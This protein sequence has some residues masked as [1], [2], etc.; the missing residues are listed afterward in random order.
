VKL[1]TKIVLVVIGLSLLVNMVSLILFMSDK[2][3]NALSQL[4]HK[5]ENIS[6]LLNQVNSGPLYDADVLVL[7]TNLKSFLNDAEI[8]SI[9]LKE[10]NGSINVHFDKPELV[11]ESIIKDETIITYNH[12]KI[13]VVTTFYSTEYIDSQ[14]YK[15]ISQL[16]ISF[17]F[18]TFIIS[19][20]LYLL[21]KK[22]T[23]PIS[24]LTVLSTEIANGN[25]EKEIDIVRYDEIGILS[26]SFMTMRDSIKSKIYSL[27]LENEE[28][29]LTEIELVKAK[30][31]IGNIINSMPSILIGV[32]AKGKVTQ[33]NRAAEQFTGL[34]ADSTLGKMLSDVYPNLESEI[35][36]ISESI[37]TQTIKQEQ[38]RK[39]LT[40]NGFCYEDVTIFPLIDS[41][42]EGVVIRID[43]VTKR[44]QLEE[45]M[46]QSERMLSIGGL[47]AGMAHEINNPL[48][49]MMQTANVMENRLV[50]KGLSA[51]LKAASEAGTSMDAIFSFMEARGILRMVT[52][53]NE[54]GR[55]IAEIVDNMLSF[56]RK[57]DVIS[58]SQNITELLDKTLELAATDYDLKKQYDFKMIRII[59]EYAEELPLVPCEG[60]KIQQVLLNLLRNGS[61]AMQEAGVENPT[62]ILRTCYEPK[63]GMVCVEV[64]DNGPG[65]DEII[66][67]RVFEPFFTT[68]PIGDGTGLGLSVSYFIITENHSGEMSVECEQ[69]KGARFIIR[70]PAE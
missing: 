66:R 30:R 60:G 20:V 51:N 21:L 7:E 56:A 13:G 40:E 18:I 11:N 5:I 58:S 14:L 64:E 39:R 27:K 53:I 37:Q 50:G 25:L 9:T 47:A 55:R 52:A 45:M 70:L 28:R 54:S 48:A 6:V 17:V 67:K 41:G 57:S 3:K 36:K 34:D 44:V 10:F 35:G 65:M 38:K 16:V 61:Q 42:V 19:L 1:R 31:L 23:K 59:R 12:E 2:R 22:I 68:K 26:Q 29:K 46:V 62:F 33:W 32:D 24:D 15:S 49:G 8:A 43:D 63:R 4:N 69:S